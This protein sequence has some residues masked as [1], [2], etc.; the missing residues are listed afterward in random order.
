MEEKKTYLVTC[1]VEVKAS[2]EEEAEKEGV[3]YMKELISSEEI[4]VDVEPLS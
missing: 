1:Q 4:Q 3:Q 2:S